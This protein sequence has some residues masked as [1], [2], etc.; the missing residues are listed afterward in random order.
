LEESALF[1]A[2][3]ADDP[4]TALLRYKDGFTETPEIF[5]TLATRLGGGL[6]ATARDELFAQSRR[7]AIEAASQVEQRLEGFMCRFGYLP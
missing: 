6:S 3:Y 2:Q 1:C 5:D 4:R 7:A